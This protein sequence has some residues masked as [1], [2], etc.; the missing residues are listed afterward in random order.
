MIDCYY[1]WLTSVSLT[2][3]LASIWP[4]TPSLKKNCWQWSDIQQYENFKTQQKKP[5]KF[6]KHSL[7]ETSW[8]LTHQSI[9]QT[10]RKYSCERAY[11]H[12]ISSLLN[13]HTIP[14]W[15]TSFS[16]AT[17]DLYSISENSSSPKNN[18]C[19]TLK[20]W[21][22][23]MHLSHSLYGLR[24]KLPALHRDAYDDKYICIL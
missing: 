9:I 23:P 6:L 10:S 21:K 22:P 7:L 3:D 15:E 13:A 24:G 11:R 2:E 8:R 14:W 18:N 1:L 5:Y 17:Q 19:H 12:D 4:K 16:L 20:H